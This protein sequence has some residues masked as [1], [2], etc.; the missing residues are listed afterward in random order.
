MKLTKMTLAIALV[1][2]TFA[3]CKQQ[4]E[5]PVTE[6]TTTTE[7]V[8]ETTAPEAVDTT[9]LV[10]SWTQPN[11]IND[12]EVQGFELKEDG[13]ATSINMATLKTNKWWVEG[14]KLFLEQESIGN[15]TSSVDTVSY[16]FEVVDGKTL[17][18]VNGESKDSFTKK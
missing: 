9:V 14:D 1:A 12:K 4:T 10:A 5:A 16:Q 7:V 3:S 18:L 8:E 6:E 17:N 13:T 15:G 2:I 11:P